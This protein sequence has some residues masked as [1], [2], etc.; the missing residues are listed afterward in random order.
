MNKTSHL[1]N[2]ILTCGWLFALGL[3][4]PARA[5]G[6]PPTPAESS[7]HEEDFGEYG[8][9]RGVFG[10][11]TLG[12][13]MSLFAVPHPLYLGLEGKYKNAIGFGAGYGFIPT[14]R[15]KDVSMA[16]SAPSANLK[17]FPF[18]G[19][20][21]LGMAVGTQTIKATKSQVILGTKVDAEVEVNSSYY[22][23]SL[24]WRWVWNS[25]F[26]MGLDFGWQIATGAET[27]LTTNVR[28]LVI[29]ATS[30][31]ATLESEVKK[32]GND[33]GNKALPSLSLIHFGWLF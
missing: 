32:A 19:A 2:L 23:P 10:D 20:L 22:T 9:P 29:L 1:R 31:Y 18:G 25:G 26:F 15:F 28:S 14:L 27:Q 3:P 11:V 7:A 30:E 17:W 16:V 4:T 24:G 21:Y 5:T 8:K 6:E 13:A 12:P 33:V